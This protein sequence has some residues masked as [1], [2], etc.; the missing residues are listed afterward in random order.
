[1]WQEPL[2]P[3]GGPKQ[4]ERA[5]VRPNQSCVQQA[6]G[7]A[8]RPGRPSARRQ[9]AL[10]S[11]PHAPAPQLPSP[12]EPLLAEMTGKRRN[13]ESLLPQTR[14]RARARG[15]A[16]PLEAPGGI[17]LDHSSWP[18]SCRSTA[19][20]QETTARVPEMTGSQHC[21]IQL[22][23]GTDGEAWAQ[24]RASVWGLAEVSSCPPAR[25]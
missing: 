8:D 22:A 12:N 9:A 10:S 19:G 7:S 11:R 16:F 21:P 13:S 18:G 5:R 17:G 24:A 4:M 2:S 14:R 3:P 20:T 25:V 23:Y 15:P 1:M 6:T